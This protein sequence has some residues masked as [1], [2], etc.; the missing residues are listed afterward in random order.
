MA[1]Q[2]LTAAEQSLA[3]ALM[4]LDKAAKAASSKKSNIDELVEVRA[5]RD[6]L[7]Q[8]LETLRREYEALEQSR[9]RAAHPDAPAGAATPP[10]RRNLKE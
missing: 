4:R 5:E 9:E 3:T 10:Q 2:Q 1:E 7:K 6:E 8:S